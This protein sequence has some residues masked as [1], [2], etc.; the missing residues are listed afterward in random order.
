MTPLPQITTPIAK[1]GTDYDALIAFG[2]SPFTAAEIAL[3][4]KRFDP[5]AR[6]VVKLARQS[7]VKAAAAHYGQMA[8]MGRGL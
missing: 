5:Y 6:E 2:L 3:N 4:A 7:D 8:Q 1:H